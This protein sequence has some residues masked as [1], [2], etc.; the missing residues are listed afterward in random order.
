MDSGKLIALADPS[1][2]INPCTRG[3]RQCNGAEGQYRST[4][5]TQANGNTETVGGR[6]GC[7]HRQRIASVFL[8]RPVWLLLPETLKP[9]DHPAWP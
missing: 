9:A 1:P 7:G 6:Q 5:G 4:S 2:L 8:I 3:R